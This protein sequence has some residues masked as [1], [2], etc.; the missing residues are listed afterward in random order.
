MGTKVLPA[1]PD[2]ACTGCGGCIS[3]C[4]KDAVTFAEDKDGFWH[5]CVSDELCIGC[6]KCEKI[7]P[8]ISYDNTNQNPECFAFKGPDKTRMISS[9]GGLFSMAA[10]AMLGMKGVVVGAAFDDDMKLALK[11]ARNKEELAPMRGSKYV[12]SDPELIYRDVMKLLKQGTPVLF[13]G[14]PC[15]VAAMKNMAGD[16]ELLYTI[17]LVCHGVP[18]QNMMHR[19]L[20]ENFP[21]KTVTDIRFRDKKNGWLATHINVDFDD[22]TAYHGQLKTKDP[23]EIIFQ[24]NYALRQ[25]C[26]DCKFSQFPRVGDISMGDFWGVDKLDASLTDGKGT[27][28]VLINSKKGKEFFEKVSRKAVVDRLEPDVLNK[29][30]NRLKAKYP[31]H[32]GRERFLALLEKGETIEGAI[33]I[34]DNNFHDVGIV[35]IHTVGNFGGALTYYAL[36]KTICDMGFSALM[37]ERPRDCSHKPGITKIYH[38]DPYPEYD[39]SKFYPN[40]QSMKELN[41]LCGQFVVGSDQLFNDLLYNNFGRWCTLDW[42]NDNKRKTAYAAS[43]GH[44]HIWSPEETRAEMAHFMRKFDAFS[45]R[46]Q[47]GVRLCREEFGVEA[48]W[49]LDPIFLCDSKH[50]EELAENS[51]LPVKNRYI[52]A[53]ILDPSKD[54]SDILKYLSRKLGVTTSIYSEMANVTNIMADFELPVNS[55]GMIEDRLANIRH[56]DLFVADSFHGICL[57][58]IMRKNFIAINNPRRGQERFT[59]ILGKLGL[60]NRLITDLAQLRERE[61]ELLEPVNYDE[62]YKKLDAE[63][64]RSRQWLY[65]SLS[66]TTKKSYSTYDILMRR[67]DELS[68]A[69]SRLTRDNAALR[70]KLQR[71][72]LYSGF[73]L[74]AIDSLEEYLKLLEKELDSYII[75]VAV[76]DT[77]GICYNASVFRLMN[78]LGFCTDLTNKHLYGYAAI[79]DA[80]VLLA[81]KTEYNK[82]VVAEALLQ[83]AHIKA[84]SNPAKAGNTAKIMVDGIDHAINQRGLNIVVYDKTKQCVCDSV[85]F[86]TH[87][88]TFN[89]TR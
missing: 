84:V 71:L 33:D 45:V 40:K 42:V 26:H 83:D 17:D 49:V 5:A 1:L 65:E 28:M 31:P 75:A 72:E 52:G 12:Q 4:P 89:C 22:G 29:V 41:S 14:C 3:A 23:Y 46:E 73:S 55:E 20:K 6:K 35:G 21:D 67:I 79:S 27:S 77:P 86:D 61:T 30:P 24:R 58:I 34:I 59:S 48:E 66:N 15:Q 56:S 16:N 47:S 87:I 32:P 39:V 37:I 57:A 18:S 60:E 8:V 80:G 9:S 36:Y 51:V 74:A 38:K 25:S 63:R 2:A 68:G 43:F 70:R 82:G 10:K 76:K 62:V 44:D 88:K 53:Y 54:K 78:K 13:T 11:I 64:V 50:Y 7:C 19:Y 85:C 69:V 81:E